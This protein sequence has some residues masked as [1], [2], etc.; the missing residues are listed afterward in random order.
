MFSSWS[1]VDFLFDIAISFLIGIIVMSPL[2]AAW[3]LCLTG[4]WFLVLCILIG[5]IFVMSGFQSY[6][7]DYDE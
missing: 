1:L 5:W 6:E 2:V 4:H 7:D 3:T